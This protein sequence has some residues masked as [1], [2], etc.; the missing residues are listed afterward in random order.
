MQFLVGECTGPAVAEWLAEQ[1][2][3]AVS[4]YDQRPGLDDASVVAWA[5][6]EDRILV[7]NDKDFGERV[8]RDGQLHAG[9]ILLRLDNERSPNKIAVLDDL[10]RNHSD[11]LEG[12]FIV[13]TEER[14]RFA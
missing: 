14:I 1:G 9:I 12:A 10:L 8:F 5:N 3:D 4:V 2:Y 11:R 13:A 7:T 6:C